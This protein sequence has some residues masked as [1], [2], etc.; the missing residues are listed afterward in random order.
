[1]FESPLPLHF[2]FL[3]HIVFATQ[4][5]AVYGLKCAHM[6]RF[7]LVESSLALKRFAQR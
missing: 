1:M 5:T 3:R 2:L 4:R 7:Q 6:P